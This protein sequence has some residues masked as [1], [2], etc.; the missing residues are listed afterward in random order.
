MKPISAQHIQQRALARVERELDTAFRDVADRARGVIIRMAGLD[1]RISEREAETI[2]AQI[3]DMVQGMF[4]SFDGRKSYN[5]VRPL[6]RYAK[7]LNDVYVFAVRET[8][9]VHHR[10]MVKH[11]P[12]DVRDFLTRNPRPLEIAELTRMEEHRLIAERMHDVM[13]GVLGQGNLLLEA[14]DDIPIDP[15]IIGRMRIF[16]P[17]PMAELDPSRRWVPMHRWQDDRGYRLSDRIWQAS[18][19]TRLKIDALLADGIRTGNSAENIANRLE[20]FLLPSR[21]PLRTNK[22]Y[23]RDGS[24]DAMRLARTEITRAVNQASFISGYL[25]PYTTGID[26]ARSFNGDPQC[27]IC[28]QHATIDMGGNRVKPPYSY[29]TAMIPPYHPH[30]KCNIR[31]VVGDSQETVT[32]NL[33]AMMDD[34]RREYLDPI[35]T[36]LMVE[37][38]IRALLGALADE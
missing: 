25:N 34:A 9:M 17:N 32:A 30:D 33:R 23:G 19:R 37:A 20:Q 10:W 29:E 21:A 8:V 16:R 18:V 31:N 27:K 12:Q 13:V 38:F 22:P 15:D 5:G 35:M 14:E 11:I 4:V 1:G 24:Y 6:S 36:P 26:V 2:Q 7:I 28:P 3:G